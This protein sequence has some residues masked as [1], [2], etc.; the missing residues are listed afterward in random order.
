M[1]IEAVLWGD[2]SE[3]DRVHGQRAGTRLTN[4]LDSTE[5]HT[6]HPFRQT[7]RERERIQN[8]AGYLDCDVDALVDG[9]LTA[10]RGMLIALPSTCP[11]PADTSSEQPHLSSRA[12]S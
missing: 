5:R 2:G 4:T 7:L 3:A 8:L 10:T 1:H 11:A 6:P 9:L 12:A